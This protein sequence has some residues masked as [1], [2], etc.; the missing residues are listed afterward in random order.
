ARPVAASRGVDA[1]EDVRAVVRGDLAAGGLPPAAGGPVAAAGLARPGPGRPGPA[2]P[3]RR[4]SPAH[5]LTSAVARDGRTRPSESTVW[6]IGSVISDQAN[7]G[8][9]EGQLW[10]VGRTSS[11]CPRSGLH[12]WLAYRCV[13]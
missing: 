10:L 11:C 3:H 6:W 5:R 9:D 2:R 13:G 4:S 12:G 1:V 8:R 7:A